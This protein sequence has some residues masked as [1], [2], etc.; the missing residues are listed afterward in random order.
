MTH[1]ARTYR[2]SGAVPSRV[3]CLLPVATGIMVC[4]LLFSVGWAHS[5]RA[6]DT[7][8]VFLEADSV[9]TSLVNGRMVSELVN[10]RFSQGNTQLRADRARDEGGDLVL[11]RGHVVIVQ[12]ADTVHADL[13]RY[14]QKTGVG[15]AEGNVELTHGDV[16]LRSPSARHNTR[17]GDTFFA[18]Q[19]RFEDSL[20][21]LYANR[22][23]YSRQ[24]NRADF[25]GRVW[26]E[27]EDIRVGAD[28]ISVSRGNDMA[29]ATGRVGIVLVDTTGAETARIFA[30][31]LRRDG[32]TGTTD[33]SGRILIAR[34]ETEPPDTL[35]IAAERARFGGGGMTAVDSVVVAADAGALRSDSM[36]VIDATPGERGQ[37]RRFFGGVHAWYED[38]Q[39]TSDSLF[40][41]SFPMPLEVDSLR[42]FG[43]VFVARQAALQGQPGGVDTERRIDQ[44]KGRFLHAVTRGEELT[45]MR[46]FPNA[47]VILYVYDEASGRTLAFDAL[48]DT[49]LVALEDGEP[50]EVLF[51]GE[52]AGTEYT[53]NLFDQVRDLPGYVWVPQL[54]PDRDRLRD[55]MRGLSAERIDGRKRQD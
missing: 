19:V 25:G 43:S 13:V 47:E 5:A 20:S 26:L 24:E 33:I 2:R 29:W 41:T 4:G 48:S 30:D 36:I 42:A 31:S 10:A 40:A 52:T 50:T 35:L 12:D 22:G 44:M 23:V 54:R 1:A 9:A 17:T 51:L 8:R 3:S 11:F 21:V 16:R 34:F 32:R 38:V 28:S 27:R 14:D 37:E 49:V 45:S 46:L 55:R 39:V 15:H 18:E 53:E 6:Q 7:E